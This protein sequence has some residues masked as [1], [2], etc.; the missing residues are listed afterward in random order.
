MQ[1]VLKKTK[2]FAELPDAD[3]AEIAGFCRQ[4][5]VMK[6]EKALTEDQGGSGDL[7]LLLRGGVDVGKK[8]TAAESA[9]TMK[10]TSVGDELFGEIAW[11][12]GSKRSAGLT[13]THDSRFLVVNGQKLRAYLEQHP[14]VGVTVLW[15]VGEV[16]SRRLV[17]RTEDLKNQKLFADMQF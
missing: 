17:Q 6:G 14:A 5:T 8:F 2:L 7:F 4:F 11:F 10:I 3:L 1:D 9:Q 12:T 15:R 13:C 16:L